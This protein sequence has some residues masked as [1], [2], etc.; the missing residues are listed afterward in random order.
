MLSSPN[1]I[2]FDPGLGGAFS[3]LF[4]GALFIKDMPTIVEDEIERIDV[5]GLWNLLDFLGPGLIA[6][7]EW[8]HDIAARSHQANKD[9][10]YMNYGRL[11]CLLECHP[12]IARMIKIV[13]ISWQKASGKKNLSSKIESIEKAI[14]FHPEMR[15]EL[16]K[17]GSEVTYNDNRAE[18]LLMLRYMDL[19]L[20]EESSGRRTRKTT[21][22]S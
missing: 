1:L 5:R 21:K 3:F 17:S 13:P 11:L 14:H 2:A 12:N 15:K 16:L 8:F 20:K 18:S 9:T 7:V 4:D 10:Q 6:G 22:R 19:K